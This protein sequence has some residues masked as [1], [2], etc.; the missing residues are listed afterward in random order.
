M[1]TTPRTYPGNRA[2]SFSRKI[3]YGL[4]EVTEVPDRSW[5]KLGDRYLL[6]EKL[7][8]DVHRQARVT[9]FK[10]LATVSADSLAQITCQHPLGGVGG[11][12]DFPVPLLAGPHVTED[13]GTGFV[14]T[15]PGHGRDD[16]ELWM[17]NARTLAARGI[18]T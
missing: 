14:H 13:T 6:A 3:G 8:V 9:G 2:I 1:T 12:Y 11:D 18:D 7:A 17:D 4:Y 15:A 5:A 10:Q 16:F